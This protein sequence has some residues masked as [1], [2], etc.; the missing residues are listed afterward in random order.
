M[1]LT[2]LHTPQAIL[3]ETYDYRAYKFTHCGVLHPH[4]IQTAY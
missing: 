4:K 1:A 3:S 2:I